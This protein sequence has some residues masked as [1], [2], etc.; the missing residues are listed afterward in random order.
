MQEQYSAEATYMGMPLPNTG[1]ELPFT[2][3][4]PLFIKEAP[5]FE[6]T[7]NAMN[8]GNIGRL[9]NEKKHGLVSNTQ[10]PQSDPYPRLVYD[11]QYG[12]NVVGSVPVPQFTKSTSR[13]FEKLPNFY[14]P[15]SQNDATLIFESRFES[16]NLA[17]AY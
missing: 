11:C 6:P 1:V 2:K 16:G 15:K 7:T 17:K 10:K 4:R 14:Q 3:R 12:A 9:L 5:T 8:R 13:Y